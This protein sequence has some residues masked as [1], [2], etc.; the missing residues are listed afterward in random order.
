MTLPRDTFISISA[1]NET[2]KCSLSDRKS[3]KTGAE[4]CKLLAA[5]PSA[6]A[7]QTVFHVQSRKPR[8]FEKGE[9]REIKESRGVMFVPPGQ[10][11]LLASLYDRFLFYA[12]RGT[13]RSRSS[14]WIQLRC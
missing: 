8:G 9:K 13:S 12:F 14:S 2:L 3:R 1:A 10:T 5:F 6:E 7:S 11:Q 4:N